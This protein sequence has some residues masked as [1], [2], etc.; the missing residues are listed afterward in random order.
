MRPGTQHAKVTKLREQRQQMLAQLEYIDEHGQRRQRYAPELHRQKV[1]EL[2][3]AYDADLVA[4][5]EEA[6]A[7]VDAAG[8]ALAKADNM[9]SWLLG[10]EEAHTAGALAPFIREDFAN[11]GAGDIAKAL[12]AARGRPRIERWLIYRYGTRRAAE[13]EGGD[14]ANAPGM[15]ERAHI[16]RAADAM[17]NDLLLPT[18]AKELADAQA[19]I[20]DGRDLFD[21]AEWSR[22]SVRQAAADR[23]RVNAE[24]LPD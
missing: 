14:I 3:A 16:T 11:M 24:Y 5:M 22:P 21:A 9:Y 8:A 7:Q 6:Q 10:P 1:Q 12:D 17:R 18:Q 19:K 20:K 15:A 23:W 4:L 13:L 2:D